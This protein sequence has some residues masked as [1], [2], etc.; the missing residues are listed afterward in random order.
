MLSYV[1]A[2]QD[3]LHFLRRRL[4]HGRQHV[5]VNVERERDTGMAEPFANYLWVL[6]GRQ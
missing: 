4:L 3:A 1:A 2:K 6:A 5:A